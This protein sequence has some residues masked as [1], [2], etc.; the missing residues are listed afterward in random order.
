M[1]QGGIKGCIKDEPFL[2]IFIIQTTTRNHYKYFQLQ[3]ISEKEKGKEISFAK[4]RIRSVRGIWN[5]PFDWWSLLLPE[6]IYCTIKS[7]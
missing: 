2:S 5:T 6:N 7:E 4:K 3:V 1:H